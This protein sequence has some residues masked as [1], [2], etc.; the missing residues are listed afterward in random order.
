[1]NSRDTISGWRSGGFLA[2][3]IAILALCWLAGCERPRDDAERPRLVLLI[4]VDQLRG[5]FLDRYG[6]RLEPGGLRR[7]IGAGVH[8]RQAHFRHGITATAPGHT[9]IVTG[10]HPSIHGLV[11][12]N[13][14]DPETG[15]SV[16][17]VQDERHRLL[18]EATHA[19]DGVS[20][21]LVEA[22]TIGDVLAE[23]TGGESRVFG[24]SLKDRG[25]ILLAGRAGK[26]FWYSRRTGR[27][28]TS[29]YYYRDP[30]PWL[31]AF[32]GGDPAGAYRQMA[33]TLSRDAG[34][35]RFIDRDDQPWE[36]D[37][38]GLGRV[39][40]HELARTGDFYS[41]LRFTPFADQLTLAAVAALMEAE[42]V[43]QRS[44]PDLLA[45]SLSATDYVG[46]VFGPDSLE[47]EDNMF[48]LDRLIAELLALAD[49]QTGP[50]QTLVILTSDH[51]I[52]SAPE[53]LVQQGEPVAR[54]DTPGMIAR[55]NQQLR[56]E[57]AL[58][59]D[60]I[61]RFYNPALFLD[62]PRLVSEGIDTE[63]LERRV[64]VLAAAEPGIESAFAA[65]DLRGGSGEGSPLRELAR[66]SIRADRAGQVYLVQ[67]PGWHLHAQPQ[68]HAAMH[69]SPHP[70]DT[71]V[72]IVVM[73]PGIEPQ[74]VTRP[75]GVES[76]AAS[77]A[78]YLDL[79]APALASGELL[80][81]LIPARS[82]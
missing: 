18:G 7:L 46:H 23:V 24:V 68:V 29:D 42:S 34:D 51:G 31:E 80:P 78:A 71:H 64:A 28:V 1:V 2:G 38:R 13:W 61:S 6:E 22:E 27:F 77:I 44:S 70:Y 12:N 56:Q 21:A 53:Y 55:L 79:P 49:R 40:P 62:L 74:S 4:V 3:V 14:V 50:G 66:A 65:G 17:C 69:G 37:Y 9:T 5:D 67:A 26:A 82:P 36:R 47:A 73:G 58:E 16:Y 72:P 54:I 81:E 39:F 19:R 41:A 11:G 75:V 10:A 48:R 20:P 33:W 30:P 35:Y 15:E 76:L 43:G 63:W 60:P 45:V 32:N 25:A 52:P 59:F 8:Y 57:M